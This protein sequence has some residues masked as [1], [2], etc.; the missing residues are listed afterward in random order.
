MTNTKVGEAFEPFSFAFRGSM[1]ILHQL[2][3]LF[4]DFPRTSDVLRKENITH[5]PFSRLGVWHR[6]GH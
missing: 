2:V 5:A 4:L 6:P 3:N 1:E